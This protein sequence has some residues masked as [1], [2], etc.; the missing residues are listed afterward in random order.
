[1]M[2]GSIQNNEKHTVIVLFH[3]QEIQQFKPPLTLLPNGFLSQ[4]IFQ[5]K[6]YIDTP[7]H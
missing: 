3:K 1:M 5:I 6:K 4:T 7:R 2:F